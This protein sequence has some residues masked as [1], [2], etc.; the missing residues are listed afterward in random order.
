MLKVSDDGRGL[1]LKKIARKGIEMG[2][3]DKEQADD[4]DLV[5]ELIFA[6]G[7]STTRVTSETSGRGVGLDSVRSAFQ[8]H[9]GSVHVSSSTGLGSTF[10]LT[11]PL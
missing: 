6:S 9:G 7:L 5:S 8:E 1:D 11:L 2:L 3:L 10:V 4:S